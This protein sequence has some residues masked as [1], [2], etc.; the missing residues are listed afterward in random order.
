MD[1]EYKLA[2]LKKLIEDVRDESRIN[3]EELE[4]QIELLKKTIADKYSQ[5]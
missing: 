5:F 3:F 2:Q 4:Y 1:T